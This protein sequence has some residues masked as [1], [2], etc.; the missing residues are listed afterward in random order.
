MYVQRSVISDR[1]VLAIEGHQVCIGIKNR[2]TDQSEPRMMTGVEFIRRYLLHALPK[3]FYHIRYR[4]FMAI[5]SE[6]E[7]HYRTKLLKP[8][9]TATNR[10]CQIA[11]TCL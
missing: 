5:I 3:G 4:G 8:C 1:R 2:D 9:N 11:K 6:P 7:S 10:P